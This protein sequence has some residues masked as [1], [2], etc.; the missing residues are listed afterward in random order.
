[1]NI[2]FKVTLFVS[3]FLVFIVGV[4]T[5]MSVNDI[6]AQGAE[7]VVNYR[8]EALGQVKEHL[9]DLVDVAYETVDNNYK[10]LSDLDYLSKY[11]ERKLHDTIN[12][13]ELIIRRYQRLVAERKISLRAAKAQAK[14][15]IGELRYD[16]GTGYVWINDTAK[17]FPKMVMH[18]TVPALDGKVLDDSS[19]NNAQGV[20]KNLFVAFVDITEG[21]T[22]DGF[23]DYLWPKP[24]ADGLTEEAPKLS[25]VRRFDDWGWILGTGI[26]LDDA[27]NE[28]ESRIKES[29]KSMRYANGTGY[30][31]INDNTLP[32]PTM[33]M[34]PALPELDGQVLDDAKFN[35]AQGVDKNLFT[36]IV[37]VTR[38]GNNEG[39]VDYLW[40]KPT[41]TGLTARTPKESYVRLHQ[42][43]GW[44]IGSGVYIDNIDEAVAVK[45]EE[46]EEQISDLVINSL[47]MAVV[48]IA[49]SVV[50][51]F[52]F[53]NTLAKPIERLTEVTRNMSLGKN[54]DEAIDEVDRKDEIG[55]LARAVVR[56]SASVKIMMARMP[57]A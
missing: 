7:R 18:P 32:Y 37:E 38:D 53:A 47:L 31:W 20:S 34:H 40:P 27:R 1:M 48:F 25:Y 41:A 55:Q 6:R 50:V 24:V 56:L 36:A 28:T 42:P 52:M 17:P 54:L 44:I 49:A 51:A 39:F 15:E 26:Y 9:K 14:K 12:T 22:K 8:T 3:L 29:I 35:N 19:Y 46:I 5:F 30:F 11:Y 43:T 45:T 2:R 21:G 57:R 16:N 13:G 33:V 23:V 4:L 10:N